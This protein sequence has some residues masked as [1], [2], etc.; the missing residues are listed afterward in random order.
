MISGNGSIKMIFFSLNYD[1]K[2]RQSGH[3]TDT[4]QRHGVAKAT[5]NYLLAHVWCNNT[6]NNI[7]WKNSEE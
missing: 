4:V 5:T 3:M 7:T 6:V 2:H 1:F